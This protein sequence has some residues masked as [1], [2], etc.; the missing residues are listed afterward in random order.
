MRSVF[1]LE[2]RVWLDG[3]PGL[4][5]LSQETFAS[6]G[7]W[8]RQHLTTLAWS[9]ALQWS[10]PWQVLKTSQ[11]GLRKINGQKFKVDFAKQ[12]RPLAFFHSTEE[13]GNHTA[14]IQDMLVGRSVSQKTTS[15]GRV[16]E[17]GLTISAHG[18]AEGRPPL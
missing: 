2:T 15:A 8:F 13:S 14:D 18:V 1:G 5:S 16:P 9:S 3:V 12:E 4:W 11:T 17:P 6:V 10:V 7:Q